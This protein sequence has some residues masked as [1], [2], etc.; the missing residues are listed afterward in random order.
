[1]TDD[2]QAVA[3]KPKI[4]FCW[5]MHQPDYR[6]RRNG[7]LQL[8]WTYL[9]GIKDYVDMVAHLENNPLAR[10][11]VNFAP[12]LLQQVDEYSQQIKQ[13]FTDNTVIKDPLLNALVD[14]A[15]P[16]ADEYRHGL[17]KACLRA[18]EQHLITRFEPY[19]RLAD[20]GKWIDSPPR[21]NSL[22]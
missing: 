1:M 17:I 21:R 15:L 5:H 6:D 18:N 22:P 10:V 9:H 12:I 16:S 3:P 8:P 2:H 20:M 19:Q 14:P 11:V 7:E 4:V 13:Y